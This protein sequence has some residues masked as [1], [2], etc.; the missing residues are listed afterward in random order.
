MAI[1]SLFL[2]MWIRCTQT[3]QGTE[4]DTAAFNSWREC[5]RP[6]R[7]ISFIKSLIDSPKV[8]GENVK[9]CSVT[10]SVIL[11]NH[12]VSKGESEE[13]S[14]QHRQRAQFPQN[15]W[16]RTT[17]LQL[18]SPFSALRK[19]GCCEVQLLPGI[20]FSLLLV[21]LTSFEFLFHYLIFKLWFF[22]SR[23]GS[24]FFRWFQ[25]ELHESDGGDGTPKR[26]LNSFSV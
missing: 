18:C 7:V 11:S 1:I 10:L 13:G 16:L 25:L 4:I 12:F 9:S 3:R 14:T 17:P 8:Y 5:S 20:V 22:Q 21:V 26:V 19:S 6:L 24:T 23:R 2:V 15:H